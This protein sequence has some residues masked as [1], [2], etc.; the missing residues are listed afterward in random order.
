ML[1]HSCGECLLEQSK[2]VFTC[3]TCN[4]DFTTGDILYFCLKCKKTEGSHE[5]KL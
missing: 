1:C 3:N 4:K 2:S 5:H